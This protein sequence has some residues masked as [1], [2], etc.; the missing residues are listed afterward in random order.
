M[1]PLSDSFLAT[2][3]SYLEGQRVA[4]V[5]ELEWAGPLPGETSILPPSPPPP[6]T[7]APAPALERETQEAPLPPPRLPGY[8]MAS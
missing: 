4:G 2:L 1:T 7:P 8:R 3:A 6:S 5:R